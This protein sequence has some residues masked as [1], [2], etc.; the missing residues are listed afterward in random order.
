MGVSLKYVVL[1][2]LFGFASPI[3]LAFLLTE[4]PKGKIL[5]RT[6]YYLPAV[7]SGIVVMF[8]WKGF[9]AQYGMINE[10]L[11]FFIGLL[12]II[13]GVAIEEIHK[14]WLRDPNFALLCVL[15]P[16]IWLGAGPGCLIY[17]AAL[18]TIPED[19]YEAADID[20]AGIFHKVFHIAIPGI[21]GLIIINFI[22]VL[23][24]RPNQIRLLK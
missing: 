15:L 23:I 14:A 13:P 10:V 22:L 16:V 5:F 21:K 2:A 11:N 3:I 4:I 12:N 8:L 17:L 24:K 7:L 6:L 9:Y 18:K 1:Y 19:L 20:G